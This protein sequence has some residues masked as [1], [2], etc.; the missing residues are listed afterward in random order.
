MQSLPRWH[1]QYVGY[2]STR[3]NTVVIQMKPGRVAVSMT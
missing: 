3:L 1:L 2:E